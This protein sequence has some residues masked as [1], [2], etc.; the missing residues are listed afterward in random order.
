[1]RPQN[2]NLRPPFKPGHPPLPGCGRPKNV[3]AWSVVFREQLG[4]GKITQE[5]IVYKLLRQATRG[6]LRAIEL[7]ITRMDGRPVQ[8]IQ[9][10]EPKTNLREMTEAELDADIMRIETE[11]ARIQAEET[12]D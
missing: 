4:Q 1:M 7:I 8:P 12:K 11:L 9:V 5:E 6:N 10:S 3:R 2:R